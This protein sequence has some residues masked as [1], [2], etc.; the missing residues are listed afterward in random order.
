MLGMSV[1]LVHAATMSGKKKERKKEEM[2]DRGLQ[3]I[4]LVDEKEW[5]ED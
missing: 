5:I 2:E 3:E 1:V 4:V